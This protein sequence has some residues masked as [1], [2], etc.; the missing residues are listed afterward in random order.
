MPIAYCF[1]VNAE[2]TKALY[3]NSTGD[4]KE[5]KKAAAQKKKAKAEAAI[6]YLGEDP[7]HRQ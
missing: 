2:V 6:E 7:I 5:A 3:G 1:L 4:S